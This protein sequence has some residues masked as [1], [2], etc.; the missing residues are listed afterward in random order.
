MEGMGNGQDYA[1]SDGQTLSGV[2]NLGL[3]YLTRGSEW[4]HARGFPRPL[5]DTSALRWLRSK[6]I[7]VFGNSEPIAIKR[8]SSVL[9]FSFVTSISVDLL[10]S[11]RHHDY[12]PETIASAEPFACTSAASSFSMFLNSRPLVN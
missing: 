2:N 12:L 1:A 4:N 10:I 11:Q 5:A 6:P 7:L 9:L 8:P 3:L